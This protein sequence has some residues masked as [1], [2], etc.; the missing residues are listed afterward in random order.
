MPNE[1]NSSPT[2]VGSSGGVPGVGGSGGATG[3]AGVEAMDRTGDN[4]L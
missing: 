3:G 1:R 2:A 4:A